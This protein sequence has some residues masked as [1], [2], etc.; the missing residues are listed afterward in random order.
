LRARDELVVV[1]LC[2]RDRR[3]GR[4]DGSGRVVVAPAL[5]PLILIG[6]GVIAILAAANLTSPA[7]EAASSSFSSSAGLYLGLLSPT[8]G[9]LSLTTPYKVV[10][11]HTLF[12][13]VTS[14]ML[15]KNFHVPKLTLCHV[16]KLTSG[17]VPKLP[18]NVP[19][20]TGISNVP[21][22][23][24]SHFC[25]R[26]KQNVNAP[27]LRLEL[28]SGWD[29]QRHV[30]KTKVVEVC[31]SCYTHYRTIRSNALLRAEEEVAADFLQEMRE[32]IYENLR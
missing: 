18:Q 14:L 29:Y 16:P 28:I 19:K 24:R 10:M 26:C 5:V 12:C 27:L 25:D 31:K 15:T 1:E 32:P 17:H 30:W 23:Y 8:I 21:K 3:G 9:I 20:L 7:A 4:S 2:D 6:A 11:S 22:N 13:V